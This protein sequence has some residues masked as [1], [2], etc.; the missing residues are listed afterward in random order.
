MLGSDLP[1]DRVIRRGTRVRLLEMD[2]S[3]Y[4]Q[5][6][7][8]LTHPAVAG[9]WRWRGRSVPFQDFERL[10]FHDV[11]RLVVVLDTDEQLVGIAALG[12]LESGD[13]HAELSVAEFPPFLGSG[14]IVQGAMLFV[15]ECFA[16]FPLRKIYLNLT[17]D[18]CGQLGGALRQAA[19]T[20]GVLHDH[21]RINGRRQNLVVAAVTP[22]S[23]VDGLRASALVRAMSPNGW[24]SLGGPV[25]T[26]D[27][28][29]AQLRPESVDELD[30][31][32][33]DAVGLEPDDLRDDL[34][35]RRDLHLDSMAMLELL[36]VLDALAG[37]EVPFEVLTATF[38][39]GDLRRLGQQLAGQRPADE[40]LSPIGSG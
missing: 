2:P 13:G 12:N 25:P 38:T 6:H 40:R 3:W 37:R 27:D 10:L 9:T 11:V 20:E 8:G 5:V 29:S 18:S 24:I 17:D 22:S 30:R 36:C 31:R 14:L 32:C 26:P 1:S 35:L 21:F 34:D 28:E 15:D 7:A 39:V 16:T 33:A 19:I 4:P 23:F